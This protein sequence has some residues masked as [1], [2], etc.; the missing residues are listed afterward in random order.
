MSK[1]GAKYLQWAPF[2]SGNPEPDNSLPNYGTPVNLGQ[3]VSV[4]DSPTYNEAKIYGD[5]ALA[6]YINEFKELGIDVEVVEL[7]TASASAI[8]GATMG[9]GSSDTDLKFSG[10]DNA[11]YG[12]LGFYI[13]KMVGNVVKYQGVYYPK[14]KAAMQGESYATKGD[15]ITLTGSKIKMTGAA[16]K[17][18]QWKVV[19]ADLESESA[20]KTWVD[21][22]IVA[23]ASG[24]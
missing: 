16:A 13:R 5:D 14:V 6:E 21:G 7:S 11:P 2:A 3:L 17:N 18:G 24:D 4:S 12:G 9:S 23:A 15:S 20:A 22:K 1:Y 8:F 10:N 19:S